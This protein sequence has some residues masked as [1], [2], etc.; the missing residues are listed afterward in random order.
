MKRYHHSKNIW[1]YLA[2]VIFPRFSDEL[3]EVLSQKLNL[4]K[5]EVRELLQKQT[6]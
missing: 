1:K 6:K 5:E 2:T 3:I 4:T